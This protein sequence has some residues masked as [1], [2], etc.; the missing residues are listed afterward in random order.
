MII[1]RMKLSTQL[2]PIGDDLTI[3]VVGLACG[4]DETLADNPAIANFSS[5]IVLPAIA[6]LYGSARQLCVDCL[7]DPRSDD[8]ARKYAQISLD[9]MDEIV[10]LTG[11]PMRDPMDDIVAETLA[12][13]AE[14]R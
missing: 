2:L 4:M 7:A 8:E 5:P 6:A 12:A 9:R 11:T 1:N 14:V 13:G 3:V 10:K